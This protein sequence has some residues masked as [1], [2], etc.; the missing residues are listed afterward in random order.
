MGLWEQVVGENPGGAA[1]RHQICEW[2][3]SQ[4]ASAAHSPANAAKEAPSV[5]T[6]SAIAETCLNYWTTESWKKSKPLFLSAAKFG[7]DLLHSNRYWNNMIFQ[8]LSAHFSLGLKHVEC[9]CETINKWGNK[10]PMCFAYGKDAGVLT[11]DR[12][13]LCWCTILTCLFISGSKPV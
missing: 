3:L 9:N 1:S 4:T 11:Q 8:L 10:Q 12:Q 6:L 5:H 2:G 7:V 13:S